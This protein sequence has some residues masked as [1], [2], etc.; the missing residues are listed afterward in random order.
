MMINS[1]LSP[2]SSTIK[3]SKESV[4]GGDF[5]GTLGDEVGHNTPSNFKKMLRSQ[6]QYKRET[7]SGNI[8]GGISRLKAENGAEHFMIKLLKGSG[9]IME[10]YPSVTYTLR[11][12]PDMI[13][14]SN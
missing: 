10:P 1:I 9:L 6:Q 13:R 11:S 2:D 12:L 5:F 3:I 8:L 4:E 14:A 7:R